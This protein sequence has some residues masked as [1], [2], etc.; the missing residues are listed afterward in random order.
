MLLKVYFKDID[1]NQAK[2]ICKELEEFFESFEIVTRKLKF[3][4]FLKPSRIK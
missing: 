4:L 2:K 1:S 3:A